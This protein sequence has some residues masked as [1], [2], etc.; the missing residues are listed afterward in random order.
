M[1]DAREAAALR[2][3]LRDIDVFEIAP[4]GC[5]GGADGAEWLIEARDAGRYHLARRWSS[6]GGAVRE[7]GMLLLSFTRW[8]LEPVY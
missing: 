4:V 6:R 1:L 8:D 3:S 5:G 7:L 2:R